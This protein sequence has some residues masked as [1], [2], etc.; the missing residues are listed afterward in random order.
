MVRDVPHLLI[1]TLLLLLLYLFCIVLINELV[2]VLCVLLVK[3]LVEEP[4]PQPLEP[5]LCRCKVIGALD[6]LFLEGQF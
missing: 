6:L 5:L 2:H 3:D 4:F 1:L